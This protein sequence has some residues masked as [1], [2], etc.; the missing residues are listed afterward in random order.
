MFCPREAPAGLSIITET[1]RTRGVP[2]RADDLGGDLDLKNDFSRIRRSGAA[3]IPHGFTIFRRRSRG[4]IIF[5][6]TSL[7]RSGKDWNP[8]ENMY[9]FP[10]DMP[11]DLISTI[12]REISA[13]RIF[14][15]E[16]SRDDLRRVARQYVSGGSGG[17]RRRGMGHRAASCWR[18]EASTSIGMYQFAGLTSVC[19]DPESAFEFWSF[20]AGPR[21]RRYARNAIIPG[22]STRR[23]RRF[24]GR[25]WNR[26]GGCLF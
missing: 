11:Y 15:K 12:H 16:T 1:L 8:M 20:S 14:E 13:G 2:A 7:S 21:E 23:F 4:A 5:W 9:F 17:D 3:I 22:Y 25:L 24:T 19:K 10:D 6:M 26:R 18:V